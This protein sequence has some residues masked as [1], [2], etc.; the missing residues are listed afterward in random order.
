MAE[1]FKNWCRFFSFDFLKGWR[2][3]GGRGEQKVE[4]FFRMGEEWIP[5][6]K[7]SM[8]ANVNDVLSVPHS[9]LTVSSRHRSGGHSGPVA[10]WPGE[11][12][13][14]T[15]FVPA[16]SKERAHRTLF[17]VPG[18]HLSKYRDVSIVS[19][20]KWV[21]LIS[22]QTVASIKKFVRLM[23]ALSWF[24]LL[25]QT[26]SSVGTRL[27]MRLVRKPFYSNLLPL[28]RF[29]WTVRSYVS[30]LPALLLNCHKLCGYDEYS[31]F[32]FFCN[33][34]YCSPFGTIVFHCIS[35]FFSWAFKIN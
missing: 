20:E 10:S 22:L 18:C 16:V 6:W 2:V 28:H 4:P 19:N 26:S 30:K 25:R 13:I 31:M 23:G 21:T 8:D 27:L 12:S 29:V 32:F 3:L 11:S 17:L 1:C 14:V 33:W 24:N 5:K 34:F 35:Q 7:G 15:A 9:T